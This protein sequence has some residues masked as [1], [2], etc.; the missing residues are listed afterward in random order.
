MCI[1]GHTHTYKHIH[2]HI[3]WNA[4]IKWPYLFQNYWWFLQNFVFSKVFWFMKVNPIHD[5]SWPR[6]NIQNNYF[7]QISSPPPVAMAQAWSSSITEMP[8]GC[9]R[10]HD[11]KLHCSSSVLGWPHQYDVVKGKYQGL[12]SPY[13]PVMKMQ[14]KTSMCRQGKTSTHLVWSQ[15]NDHE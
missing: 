7:I 2:T 1:C 11:R 15:W 13:E 3:N 8:K 4:I 14:I 6:V 9:W 5:I 10:Q 12:G